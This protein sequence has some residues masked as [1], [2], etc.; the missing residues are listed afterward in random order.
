MRA[1]RIVPVRV[2]ILAAILVVAAIGLVG[3]GTI[4]YLLERGRELASV[5]EELRLRLE[6]VRLVIS[7]A[8]PDSTVPD[9][10]GHRRAAFAT[11]DELVRELVRTVSPP[12]DGSAVGILNGAARYMPGVETEFPLT[13][14]EF[15]RT[16][17]D[18]TAGP[19]TVIGTTT[20][21]DDAALRYL[22]VGLSADE[23]AGPAVFAAAIDVGAR[24]RDLDAVMTAYGWVGAGTLVVIGMVGWF[25]ARRLVHPIR[26]LRAA[27]ARITATDLAER[28]PVSGNDDL[29]DLTRTVNGMIARLE[30]AFA[31]QQRLLD[32]VRHELS[33][34]I[35][36]IRGHLELLD[37]SDPADVAQ[38]RAVALDE[39]D[40]MARL[41][42]DIAALA[43]AERPAMH[44]PTRTS[45]SRLT[46][47]VHGK[48]RVLPGHDW[49]LASV[50]TGTALLDPARITQA[51]LQLADN[52]AKFAP[53]GSRIRVG[54]ERAD[55][56]VVFWVGDE[57]PGIPD[58]ARE[59]I[60]ERFG[61]ASDARGVAGS[62]L[63][64]AIVL[65]IVRQH[66]GRV[67]VES[68]PGRGA[69]FRMVLPA[70]S[71]PDDREERM[72]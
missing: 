64:L 55:G 71:G 67:D 44:R 65:A 52:A 1:R 47:D 28:I 4:A 49:E 34:P 9:T 29:S 45:V 59:R 60:F 2:R 54:S 18:A 40:R 8:G 31:G 14:P 20:G 39:L 27:A 3:A 50:A 16:V 46:R 57:G 56:D 10:S 58:E 5:D 17:V 42:A 61:R 36:I 7:G 69:L 63:G 19:R 21:P 26:D 38:A 43:D 33:T 66:G 22:A 25:A 48:L 35:T 13:D 70:G 53:D 51:W 11:T 68:A 6:D 62:G 32:D 12:A 72:R 23:D 37:A 24:M 41:V 15:V 30:A